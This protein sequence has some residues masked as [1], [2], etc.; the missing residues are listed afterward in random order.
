VPSATSTPIATAVAA[1]TP[2]SAPGETL[3]PTAAE[4]HALL[5]TAV[6]T[7]VATAIK[8]DKA[9]PTSSL[10]ST[11]IPVTP[12]PPQLEPVTSNPT[13]LVIRSIS[14]DA[15]VVRVGNQ[16]LIIDGQEAITWAVPRYFAAGWHHTSAPPGQV[17]N[18]VLNGHQNGY[19][20]VFQDLSALQIGEEIVLYAGEIPFRYQVA[21]RVVIAEEDQPLAVR[22][23]NARWIM[24][25]ADQRLTLVTCA[26]DSA[27]THR[28]IIVAYPTQVSN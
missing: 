20:A 27:I 2:I 28:L 18:T 6:A 12:E 7:A 25:T 13:R 8:A 4:E 15:P 5:S 9:T 11:A 16:K 3:I 23:Q 17:G 26:P 21:N 14:L 22:M 10:P 19:G 24:P 1:A